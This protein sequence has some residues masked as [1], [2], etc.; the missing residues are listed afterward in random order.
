VN[1]LATLVVGG[2][3]CV[4]IPSSAVAGANPGNPNGGPPVA[5]AGADPE[6]GD[7][8]ALVRSGTARTRSRDGKSACRW[9]RG[10]L[11]TPSQG[12]SE[13]GPGSGFEL[14]DDQTGDP[15]VALYG[16]SCG[17]ET[18]W[19]FVTFQS[20]RQLADIGFDEVRDR[21]PKPRG[22][23]SPSLEGPGL[24]AVVNVPLWFAVPANQWKPVQATASR[25]GLSATVTATPVQL[26]FT[27][28]GGKG[29]AT[30]TGPGLQWSPE[31][32]EPASPPAC[33][34]VYRDASTVAPNGRTWSGQLTMRW[35]VRWAA[36]NG[37]SGDLGTLETATGYEIPVGEVQAVE[38]APDRRS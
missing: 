32:A 38:T 24:Q 12:F 27:P 25:P 17:D 15:V 2:T 19:F 21:L 22:V 23:F 4:G 30:C 29:A 13:G 16:R 37:E 14:V 6:G 18:T 3:C 34:Y 33:S 26:V 20:A 7:I 28:G 31:M 11:G 35:Q 36:T 10:S 1:V 5:T 9:F 8:S